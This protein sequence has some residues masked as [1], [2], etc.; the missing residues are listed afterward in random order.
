MTSQTTDARFE[1]APL[2]DK[3]LRLKA[4][5]ADDLAVISSLLQDAVGKAADIAWMPKKRRMVMLVNRFRWEDSA[6]AEKARRPFERVRSAVTMDGVLG[7][8]AR[9]IVPASKDQAYDLL[10]IL[11]EPAE[12]CAGTLTLM[13]AGDAEISVEVECLDLAL[14]DLT[15]PWEAKANHAPEHGE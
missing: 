13:L 11:F 8:R 5:G 3:P 2:S 6:D 4:E 9:G 1:D 14:S 10:A 15:R 7:V 12:D